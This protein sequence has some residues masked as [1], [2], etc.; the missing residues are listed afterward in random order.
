M[1]NKTTDWTNILSS[2]S[3]KYL[4]TGLL[5]LACSL[6]T[7][8]VMLPAYHGVFGK[9]LVT[10]PGA[11]TSPIATAGNVQATV[12]FTAPASTGGSPITGYT[13][14]SLPSGFTASG[15]ASPITVT[16]LTN[17]TS[18]SFTVAATNAGGN[19]VASVASVA[20]TP[21]APFVCGTST[22]TFTYNGASV[23]YG[24]VS[25]AY[26]GGVGTKCWLDRNLGATRVATS[27]VDV[28]SYG[29][30]YQ[31]GRGTDGHQIRTS[32]TTSTLSSGDQPPTGNFIAPPSLPYDWRSSA[33]PNLWQGINGVNNPCPAG[34][35]IPTQ[36]ELVA[37]HGSWSNQTSVGAF[38]T[39]LKLTMAG[40]HNRDGVLFST[41]SFGF[42]WSSTVSSNDAKNLRFDSSDVSW[43]TS[44]R[45]FGSSV[46]C[47]KD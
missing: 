47:I 14:T 23:T 19:S 5:F 34:F 7:A 2:I 31:W 27:S 40:R 18:Y 33:N 37:E 35:R 38:A 1:G 21:T 44:R 6:A 28:N 13:V 17:G 42:Y 8:Q 10:V 12:S 29:D 3:I 43:E 11:P 16:G 32:A 24:T 4:L 30:L 26:G 15:A 45:A 9:K 46:R 39:P 41:N 25:R 22:V 20:V 36:S